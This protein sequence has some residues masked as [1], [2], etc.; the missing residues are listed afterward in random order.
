MPIPQR[1]QRAGPITRK[2]DPRF[3]LHGRQP[4]SDKLDRQQ[5]R[6]AIQDEAFAEALRVRVSSPARWAAFLA[7]RNTYTGMPCM[8]CGSTQRRVRDCG[9][10]S[11]KR[12]PAA[13]G[14]IL[15]GHRPSATRS[16]DSHNQRLAML[17]QG[18]RT[19]T[20]GP[21]TATV[22]GLDRTTLHNPSLHIACADLLRAVRD[23]PA[24]WFA[25]A[26]RDSH[27]QTLLSADLGW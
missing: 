15:A 22:T 1:Q 9:C 8:R 5:R 12:D 18:A 10:M 4:R 6:L 26:E 7:G 14:A 25:L 2:P 20:R 23:N 16:R 21:W 27:L 3:T 17:K 13:W 24:H 19:F 11:C